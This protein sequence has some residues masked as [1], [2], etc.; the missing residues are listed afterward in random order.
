MLRITLLPVITLIFGLLMSAIRTLPKASFESYPEELPGAYTGGFGEE[1]CHSC[2]FDYPLNP[3]EGTLQI[4][5]FPEN[6]LPEKTYTF[7][8][9]L[10]REDLGR[11]GF[12]I[13]SRFQD[14][15]QAGA[16]DT[17]SDTVSRTE[18]E[19]DIQ[20]V[21]HNTASSAFEDGSSRSWK[22]T[23]TAPDSGSE[24]ILFHLATNAANGDASAFGD[25]IFVKE[26]ELKAN[27]K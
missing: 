26:L 14:G 18:I 25:F 15:S 6:Y 1:T 9:T 11:A 2:H 8:I 12:Q 4:T 19:G 21:Q 17:G 23:W 20:Y 3:Q 7:S 16:F 13:S 27:T 22:I 10:S 5:G 24:M